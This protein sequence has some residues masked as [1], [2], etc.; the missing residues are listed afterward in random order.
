[1]RRLSRFCKD[2]VDGCNDLD[3]SVSAEQEISYP[4]GFL[5]WWGFCVFDMA[6][7]LTADLADYTDYIP[8]H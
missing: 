5:L 1:M 6:L 4:A 7:K 3:S 8:V 2:N